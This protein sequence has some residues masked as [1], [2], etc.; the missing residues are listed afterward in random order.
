MTRLAPPPP[1]AATAARSST[2]PT[3]LRWLP[4]WRG[5]SGFPRIAALIGESVERWGAAAEPDLEGIVALDAEVRAA[6][7]VELGLGGAG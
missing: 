5:R 3:R 1:R 2:P 6:L 4:S 7:T